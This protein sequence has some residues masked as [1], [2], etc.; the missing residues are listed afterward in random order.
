MRLSVEG[1]PSLRLVIPGIAVPL[2][3]TLTPTAV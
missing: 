2:G 1:D 3:V